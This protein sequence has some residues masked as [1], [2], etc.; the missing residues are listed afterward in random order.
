M[1]RN[2]EGFGTCWEVFSLTGTK[3]FRILQLFFGGGRHPN[4]PSPIGPLALPTLRA[5]SFYGLHFLECQ[6]KNFRKITFDKR[7]PRPHNPYMNTR[8]ATF[9]DIQRHAIQLNVGKWAIQKWRQ[10]GVPENWQIKIAQA[11]AGFITFADFQRI[12]SETKQ[13]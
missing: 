3:Q 9:E 2:L 4:K 12:E 8:Q 6:N 13:R 1:L 10:R 7:T 5:F 11:S